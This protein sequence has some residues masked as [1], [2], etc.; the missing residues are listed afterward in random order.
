MNLYCY[1]EEERLCI[2]SDFEIVSNHPIQIPNPEATELCMSKIQGCSYEG[3]F[4]A[5]GEGKD[6][7]KGICGGCMGGHLFQDPPIRVHENC[8]LPFSKLQF[9]Y[10]G[11]TYKY[12]LLYVNHNTENCIGAAECQKKNSHLALLEDFPHRD[13]LDHLFIF[14]GGGKKLVFLE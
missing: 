6:E 14:S 10:Q 3:N 13:M 4:Y 7:D 2:Q 1:K 5:I 12:C 11:T 9:D 8:L